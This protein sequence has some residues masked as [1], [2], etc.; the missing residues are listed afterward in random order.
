MPCYERPKTRCR[1][2]GAMLFLAFWMPIF[3]LMEKITKASIAWENDSNGSAPRAV[4]LVVR[5]IM[6][7]MWW[8]H[9]N[10][11]A[12]IW[13]RGDGRQVTVVEYMKEDM[14]LSNC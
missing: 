9:D 12:P 7:L 6:Q 1:R 11:H 2:L 14:M 13:G 3:T 10:V 4:I 8:H 5:S